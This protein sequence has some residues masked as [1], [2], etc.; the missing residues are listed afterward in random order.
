MRVGPLSLSL[1]L[2]LTLAG[3][4]LARPGQTQPVLKDDGSSSFRAHAVKEAFQHAWD[5][6]M[7][8]AFPHDELHPVSDGYGD[9][10]YFTCSYSNQPR[11]TDTEMAGARRRSMPCPLPS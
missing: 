10:R 2:V 8:Y 11:L 9:S 1:P 5:G 4:S 6:Y 7:K 3:P